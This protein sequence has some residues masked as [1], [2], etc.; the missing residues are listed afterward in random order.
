MRKIRGGEVKLAGRMRPDQRGGAGDAPG[1]R[2]SGGR[3]WEPAALGASA[4]PES[5]TGRRASGRQRKR[6]PSETRG[7]LCSQLRGGIW[8]GSKPH[9]AHSG[10]Q[11]R[12]PKSL[13]ATKDVGWMVLGRDSPRTVIHLDA[14]PEGRAPYFAGKKPGNKGRKM[15]S[16]VRRKPRPDPSW[17]R[18]AGDVSY[19]S[20]ASW[21]AHLIL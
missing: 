21:G 14:M 10:G 16:V 17:S 19:H 13:C 20:S 15:H 8:L 1:T 6:I 9:I 18:A 12:P 11:R 4:E 5:G 7:A 2:V 3:R